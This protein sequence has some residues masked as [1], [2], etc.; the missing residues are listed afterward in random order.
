[1]PFF[2]ITIPV[3]NVEK[4]IHQ[5]LDSVMEQT[6]KDF[7]VIILDD[8]STDN[9]GNICDEYAHKDSRVKVIHDKN[10]GLLMARRRA[11]QYVKGEYVLFLDS[12]DYWEKDLL[13]NIYNIF[14]EN[15]IDMVFFRY[16]A[17]N[18]E[19]KELYQQKK[20]LKDKELICDAGKFI[21]YKI[22]TSFEYN[23]MWLKCIKKD[24]IDIRADYSDVKD[25]SMGED[26]LQS[27]KIAPNI[28]NMVYLDRP[29]YNYRVNISSISTK[30]T[31]KHLQDYLKVRTAVDDAMSTY[32]KKDSSEYIQK[33]EYDIRGFVG[34]LADS[35][36]SS[37]VVQPKWEKI[38]KEIITSELFW[39]IS[40]YKKQ[41]SIISKVYIF[42][43]LK[44]KRVIWK[45]LGHVKKILK[46][47]YDRQN[48]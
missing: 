26:A 10:M 21:C 20:L 5:C 12:D 31:E 16:K 13:E 25:V 45:I 14:S 23:T 37:L 36:V 40:Q 24:K 42:V 6:F 38:K 34:L 17:V 7:E 28:G 2:S 47:I 19:G 33:I 44:C 3:Y 32:Y 30:I 18:A 4:Y 9:S 48:G 46:Y 15:K 1:M 27:I 11:L 39:N 22:A 8:G 43:I 41:L 29:L 35:A